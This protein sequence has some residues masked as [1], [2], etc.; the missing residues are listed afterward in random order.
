MRQM[1]VRA[2]LAPLCFS[3]CLAAASAQALHAQTP[4]P[5]A[6]EMYV[7]CLSDRAEQVIYFSDVFTGKAD[8]PARGMRKVSF[9]NIA[10]DFLVFLQK[11]YSYKSDA[12][13]PTTCVGR[14]SGSADAPGSKQKV[15]DPFKQANKQI[16]ET[17][18]KNTP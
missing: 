18:W 5:A 11:K 3:V 10:K 12:S 13:Y 17:G 1:T 7:Y 6:G 14:T 2:C 9:R 4:T 8:P 16:I 15:E